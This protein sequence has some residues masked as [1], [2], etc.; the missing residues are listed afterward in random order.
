MKNAEIRSG[1]LVQTPGIN[2][3]P[4]FFPDDCQIQ[5]IMM[6]HPDNDNESVEL[7]TWIE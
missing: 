1:G 2:L 6:G 5:D 3:L 7:L 4:S